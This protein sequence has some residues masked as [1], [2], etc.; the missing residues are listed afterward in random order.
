MAKMST[1][2]KARRGPGSKPSNTRGPNRSTRTQ[3]K[4][5]IAD[6][7]YSNERFTHVATSLI[8]C[9]VQIQVKNGDIY[10]GILITFSSEMKIVLKKVHKITEFGST[11]IPS[12]DLLQETV[13]YSLNDVVAINAI[14]VDLEYAVKDSFTDSG[15]SKFNGQIGE[16][17]LTPW[18]SEGGEELVLEG[19]ASNGWDPNEMFKTNRE[20]F[21]VQSTYDDKLSQY[22]TVLEKSNSKEYRRREEMANKLAQEIEG[23]EGYRARQDLENGDGNEEDKFSA[24]LRPM[25]NGTGKYTPP[26]RRNPPRQVPHGDG[27]GR[28]SPSRTSQ[29]PPQHHRLTA[30]HPPPGMPHPQHM[31]SVQPTHLQPAT[32]QPTPPPQQTSPSPSPHSPSPHNIQSQVLTPPQTPPAKPADP[33]TTDNTDQSS[34]ESPKLPSPDDS[35]PNTETSSG[36]SSQVSPPSNKS[37][38]SG[39]SRD[40]LMR[41]EQIRELREFGAQFKLSDGE[42]KASSEEKSQ[43]AEKERLEGQ[44]GKKETEQESKDKLLA[45]AVKKSTLN[46][47]AKVFNPNAK[48]FQPKHSNANTPTPPRPQ[49]QSPV[50][51]HQQLGPV[52]LA[53]MSGVMPQPKFPKRA[54]VSVSQRP[55]YNAAA[56]AAT[57]QPLLAQTTNPFFSYQM[58]SVQGGMPQPT[59]VNY[60]QLLPVS[61]GTRMPSNLSVMPNNPQGPQEHNPQAQYPVFM[62]PP[63]P[64]HL[65]HPGPQHPPTPAHIS[66]HPGVGHHGQPQHPGGGQMG[67]QSGGHHPAP[68]PVQHHGGPGSQ[69][70][71]H[72]PNSGTPQP[73]LIFP[74]P[75]MGQ[76]SHPPLQ[77]SPHN[78]T[79]PSGIHH[80]S[81]PAYALNHP[82]HGH[83]MQ[84][85]PPMSLPQSH[86]PSSGPHMIHA[87]SHGGPMMIHHQGHSQMQ[88]HG[89]MQ[90]SHQYPGHQVPTHVG[91]PGPGPHVIQQPGMGGIPVSQSGNIP[92]IPHPVPNQ[93]MPQVQSYPHSQ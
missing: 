24:V 6:G 25:G 47:N 18:E 3:E 53:F 77:A 46:P 33:Q 59:H 36:S 56:Q 43:S 20:Q 65:P 50:I 31:Q 88:G 69:P 41:D 28:S 27:P 73:H 82:P 81:M 44:P 85:A 92:Y 37:D 83:S 7:I 21:N 4:N 12:R 11:A 49:T 30:S 87:H 62:T 48:S 9:T 76:Q 78:P 79:S 64:A 8:G 45:E 91:N 71:G 93:G 2:M 74:G 70:G 13:V 29:P 38:H 34:M 19:D 89:Q 26:H 80:L 23:T 14:D 16:K 90:P 55:D 67:P 15:I 52:Q 42:S 75:G 35:V 39:V 66:Q 17:E 40:D 63:V 5:Y 84:G 58:V 22:T 61:H 10:D 54:V 1:S 57:G 32:V 72:P 86:P 51:A 60:P 68:S